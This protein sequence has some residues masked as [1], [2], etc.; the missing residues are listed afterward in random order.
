MDESRR[1]YHFDSNRVQCPCLVPLGCCCFAALFPEKITSNRTGG[2]KSDVYSGRNRDVLLDED[3][4][5]A[6]LLKGTCRLYNVK[7]T[8]SGTSYRWWWD[9][10]GEK[11]MMAAMRRRA[12]EKIGA[13]SIKTE[14]S[15][16]FTALLARFLSHPSVSS[17]T[18]SLLRWWQQ[19]DSRC[20]STVM[21]W[22]RCGSTYLYS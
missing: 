3:S 11:G 18:W 9:D 7:E 10:S 22:T 5:V 2:S 21:E 1:D 16:T 19:Q 15:L 4:W 12:H 6:M 14:S 13:S 17:L 8:G 20:N